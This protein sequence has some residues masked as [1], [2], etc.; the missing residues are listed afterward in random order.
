[1][2]RRTEF[3]HIIYLITSPSGKQYVGMTMK[4]LEHR[5]KGHIA[6]SSM[7]GN[8]TLLG[9][10]IRKYGKD[11]FIKSVLHK[12][13]SRRIAKLYEG[14]FI[15]R[16]NT[17]YP[18]GYNMAPAGEGGVPGRIVS[19][20]TRMLLSQNSSKVYN[21]EEGKKMQRQRA[22]NQNIPEIKIRIKASL[23]KKRSTKEYREA[24]SIE[25]KKVWSNPI[26]KKKH[27]DLTK[28]QYKK[29]RVIW[30][31]GIKTGLFHGKTIEERKLNGRNKII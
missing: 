24:K 12:S 26:L 28:E 9:K 29:G 30:N 4:S 20:E 15:K 23:K 2:R 5:W 8:N 7:K 22:Y 10:A 17:C 14:L 13:S 31:K 25:Q 3:P 19:T 6:C 21:T 16:F 1:M 27:S 18:D 11:N